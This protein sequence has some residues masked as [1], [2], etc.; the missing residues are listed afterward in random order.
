MAR[1]KHKGG[2][3]DGKK[4]HVLG[5]TRNLVDASTVSNAQAV[6]RRT[7]VIVGYM[8]RTLLNRCCIRIEF[9]KCITFGVSDTKR[10]SNI[11]SRKRCSSKC[12]REPLKHL[13]SRRKAKTTGKFYFSLFH[14]G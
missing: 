6:Q 5:V 13:L 4:Q 1:C 8:A 11:A 14:Q 7:R 9:F 3:A 10:P 2:Q 12:S